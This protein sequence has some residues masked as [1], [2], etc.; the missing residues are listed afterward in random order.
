MDTM[1]KTQRFSRTIPCANCGEMYSVTYKRCPFCGG[2]TPKRQERTPVTE[3]VEY[4]MNRTQMDDEVA[5]SAPVYSEKG[6]KR[7][8]KQTGSGMFVRLILFLVSL[9]IIVAA[10]YIIVTKVV[11]IVQGH[12]GKSEP[13]SQSS[14]NGQDQP[15]STNPGTEETKTGFRLLDLK[16]TLTTKGETK[17]LQAVFEPSEKQSTLTWSSSNTEV[18]TV[19]QQGKLTAVAPGTAIITATTKDGEKAECEVNCLWDES[20]KNA[21]LSL[22]RTDFTLR[23]GQSFKMQVIGTEET[24]VWNIQDQNVAAISKDGLVKFVANGKTT[25]TATVGEQTLTCVLYCKE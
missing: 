10:A 1:D 2:P 15:S 12:F 11:P 6:G 9:A 13:S 14:D 20:A 25:I 19:D 22:N 16:A 3:T 8:K 18:A 17:Q 24:P 5:S 7:L 21:N 23:K 4:D